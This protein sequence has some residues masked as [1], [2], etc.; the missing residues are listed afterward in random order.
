MRTLFNRLY[1]DYVM[2]SRLNMHEQFIRSASDAGYIQTSVR[3]FLESMRDGHAPNEKVVIHRHDIDTDVRT[4]RK[5]FAVEKKHNIRSSYYFRLSTLD[6]DLMRE[7]E[8]YGSEASYH[9]EELATFAKENKVTNSA[10]I[11]GRLPEI[12]QKFE[13]NFRWIEQMLGR[14]MTT[15]ASHGDFANR[16][17][18]ICNT[19][20]LTDRQLRERCGIECETYDPV[21]MEN[22]DIYIS[23]RPYPQYYHPMP[24][25]NALGRHKRIYL[26][27]HPR[28]C[29]TNWGENTKDNLFRFYEGLTW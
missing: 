19:E 10:A 12:K 25:M 14:K 28:Q 20:I 26:L 8:E 4:A 2:P 24:P 5:L 6:L 13:Q 11:H 29:E 16:R 22:V 9:Y 3:G 23:D 17:L 15:V 7:I 18:K 1:S 27:T 21:L